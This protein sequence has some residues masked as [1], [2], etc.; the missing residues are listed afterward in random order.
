MMPAVTITDAANQEI[1]IVQPMM[2]DMGT[3]DAGTHEAAT[4]RGNGKGGPVVNDLRRHRFHAHLG[5]LAVG[6]LAC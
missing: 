4:G 2:A 6:E 5:E 1:E 3:V